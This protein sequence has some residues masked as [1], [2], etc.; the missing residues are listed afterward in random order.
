[1]T[2]CSDLGKL[3][4]ILSW[5]FTG[6]D[7]GLMPPPP[8]KKDGMQSFNNIYRMSFFQDS[9]ILELSKLK[10]FSNDGQQ[11]TTACYEEFKANASIRSLRSHIKVHR[12]LASALKPE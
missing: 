6:N 3:Y 7:N 5:R 10:A 11:H 12:M 4:R 8:P 9:D 1:M 2:F